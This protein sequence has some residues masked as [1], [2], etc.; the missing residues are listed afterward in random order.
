MG[1]FRLARSIIGRRFDGQDARKG[2]SRILQLV[3]KYQIAWNFGGQI[4]PFCARRGDHD[5]GTLVQA[6]TGIVQGID[7]C[8]GLK[9]EVASPVHAFE[10]MAEKVADIVDVQ[11]RIVFAGN[12]Q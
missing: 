11:L 9:V 6:G 3:G 4:P 10:Q 8:S 7:G 1:R 12:D 5:L 2:D